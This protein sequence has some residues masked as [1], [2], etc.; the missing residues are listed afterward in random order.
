MGLGRCHFTSA[1]ADD[2]VVVGIKSRQ[3]Q[4]REQAQEQKQQGPEARGKA[5]G[6]KT[7]SARQSVQGS[8]VG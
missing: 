2:C 5:G 1:I 3:E 6:C 8:R 4:P 7:A